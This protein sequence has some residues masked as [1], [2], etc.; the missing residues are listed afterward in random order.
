MVF[1]YPLSALV[2]DATILYSSLRNDKRT[3]A[4]RPVLLDLFSE[5][6][7][8]GVEDQPRSTNNFSSEQK[9]RMGELRKDQGNMLLISGRPIGMIGKL[10]SSGEKERT[11]KK[12]GHRRQF[13]GKASCP[14]S[15]HQFQGINRP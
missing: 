14:P 3:S 2:K 8:G 11:E 13:E 10:I 4:P 15:V 7:G 9:F 1:R 5:R 6:S 12:R